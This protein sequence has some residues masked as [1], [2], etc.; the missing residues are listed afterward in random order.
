MIVYVRMFLHASSA[1]KSDS[2]RRTAAHWIAFHHFEQPRSNGPQRQSTFSH[3]LP[4]HSPSAS[5]G[6]WVMYNTKVNKQRQWETISVGL[7]ETHN[8]MGIFENTLKIPIEIHRCF[9]WEASRV[10]SC[11][12]G[13]KIS[14][15]PTGAATSVVLGRRI[16]APGW[17]ASDGLWIASTM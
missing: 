11:W 3:E 15:L 9:W 17:L 12:S 7:V 4:Q 2:K 16:S 8:D 13:M 10:R 5:G 14:G 6:W 1:V